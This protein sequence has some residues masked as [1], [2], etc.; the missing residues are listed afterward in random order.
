MS[1]TKEM[2]K[3]DLETDDKIRITTLEEF[4]ED[5]RCNFEIPFGMSSEEF[6]KRWKEG[7][8]ED[9][10]WTTRWASDLIT[11]RKLE[12]GEYGKNI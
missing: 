9:T 10:F 7:A 5:I 12:N 8:I 11:L 4:R 3:I 1:V 2:T 6:W